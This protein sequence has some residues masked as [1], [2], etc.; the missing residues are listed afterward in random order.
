MKYKLIFV[1]V[2]LG[3]LFSLIIV[4]NKNR[5]DK[6]KLRTE[7]SRV[8]AQKQF[9]RDSIENYLSQKKRKDEL[10]QHEKQQ[11]EQIVKQQQAEI[12][13]YTSYINPSIINSK[14]NIEI[15]VTVVDDQGNISNAISSSVANIYNQSGKKSISSLFRNSFVHSARFQELF[16]GN[17]SVIEKL[18]LSNYTDYVG[19]GKIKFDT[20]S[21]ILEAGTV[22]CT[23]SISMSIVSVNNK[24]IDRSFTIS[25]NANGVSE[26]QAVEAA[27]QKLINKYSNE[28]SS[29]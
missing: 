14:D 28:Y 20:H 15:A 6:E 24:A 3:T 22:V 18:K 13:D 29:L 2:V 5:G 12:A 1:F 8:V 25:V 23:A 19:L 7:E 27:S 10:S 21:G 16:E 4:I 11:Q 9:V 17:S 26:A